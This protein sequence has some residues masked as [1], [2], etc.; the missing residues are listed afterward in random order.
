MQRQLPGLAE[1]AVAHHDQ[2]A[3]QVDVAAVERD[4]LTDPH[5]GGGQQPDQRGIGRRPQPWS[6]IVGSGH[7]RGDVGIG[8]QIRH[9]A[10]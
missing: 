4:H 8:I 9:R 2:S 3:A 6:Q 7:H 10:S 5:P 1:L